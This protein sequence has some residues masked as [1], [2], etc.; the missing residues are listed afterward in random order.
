MDA[1]LG[2][3]G[4]AMALVLTGAIGLATYLPLYLS[5]GR[6]LG[7]TM[8]AWSVV[9]FTLGWTTGA[10]LSSRLMDRIPALR[11]TRMGVLIVVPGL[12]GVSLCA[13]VTAPLPVL[14][15][16]IMG[17]AGIQIANMP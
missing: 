7:A 11:V 6:G 17:P 5:A 8:T 2:P 1:P 4:W 16:V 15:A 14:F 13:F 10:N 9:F 3:L 12:V